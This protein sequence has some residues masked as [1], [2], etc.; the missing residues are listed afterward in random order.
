[1]SL[2]AED[3]AFLAPELSCIVQHVDTIKRGLPFSNLA[4]ARV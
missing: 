1:M 2:T 4:G 3:Y